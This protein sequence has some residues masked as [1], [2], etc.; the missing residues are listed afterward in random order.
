MKNLYIVLL[1]SGIA[2]NTCHGMEPEDIKKD[3]PTNTTN[4]GERFVLRSADGEEFY[5]SKASVDKSPVLKT[6]FEKQLKEGQAKSV[7]LKE[8]N[9]NTLAHIKLLLEVSDLPRK[10]IMQALLKMQNKKELEKLEQAAQFLVV[11][12]L[13]EVNCT[14]LPLMQKITE[15]ALAKIKIDCKALIGSKDFSKETLVGCAIVEDKVITGSDDGH[16]RIWD[17]STSCYS[18]EL[19]NDQGIA[20]YIESIGSQLLSVSTNRDVMI[21]D[22]KGATCTRKFTIPDAQGTIMGIT[23]VK[24]KL[25][26]RYHNGSVQIFDINT[27]LLLQELKGHTRFVDCI[28]VAGDKVISGSADADVRIWDINTGNCIKVLKGHKGRVCAVTVS[29]DKIISGSSDK[30]LRI[31]DI[32]SYQCIKELKGDAEAICCVTASADIIIS[33]SWDGALRIW[34][35]NSGKCLREVKGNNSRLRQSVIEGDRILFY[36]MDGTISVFDLGLINMWQNFL[37]NMPFSYALV[38][39]ARNTSR[40]LSPEYNELLEGFVHTVSDNWGKEVADAVRQELAEYESK[41]DQR[42]D[43]MESCNII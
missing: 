16:L 34:D 42:S 29:G 13:L 11:E 8:I 38:L 35:M 20:R 26:V 14:L 41:L 36:A 39:L 2:I 33:G 23:P 27:G 7:H 4:S 19:K 30:T 9:T 31:W 21:W 3:T 28:T 10:N 6:M 18:K 43:Y 17:I 1:V 24:E 37:C 12:D 15:A 40:N 32:N 25:L 22:V 5:I